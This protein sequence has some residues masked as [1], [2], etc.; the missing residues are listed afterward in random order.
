MKKLLLILVLFVFTSCIG[1][2]NK[3]GVVSTAKNYIGNVIVKKISIQTGENQWFI[4]TTK[5]YKGN[6]IEFNTYELVFNVN[7]SIHIDIKNNICYKDSTNIS[8][9]IDWRN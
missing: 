1:T 5:D 7:D 9:I 3:D 4:V 6:K 2:T 8:S